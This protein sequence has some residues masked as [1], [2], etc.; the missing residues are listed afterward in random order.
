MPSG[1]SPL[2]TVRRLSAAAVTTAVLVSAALSI[3]TR[4]GSGPEALARQR[5]A[6]PPG[7]VFV[8]AGAFWMGSDDADAEEDSR[9]RRWVS[10]DSFYIGRTEVTNAEFRRFRTAFAYPPGCDR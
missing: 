1:L 3:L 2:L 6:T 7:M 8:P 4:R 9:P 5:A 10:V